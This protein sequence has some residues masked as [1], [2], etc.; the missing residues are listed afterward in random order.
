[1]IG[2]Y[3]ILNLSDGKM[4][5]GSG[6]HV[7]SRFG[8]HL[9]TLR[10]GT[11]HNRY[12]QE[13]WDKDGEGNFSFLLLE[14]CS[15]GQQREREQYWLD[16]V[17]DKYNISPSS[18]DGTFAEEHKRRIAQSKVGVPRSEETKRK[19]SEKLRGRRVTFSEE[20]RK[21]LSEARRRN[22]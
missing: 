12:L 14:E 7:P 5:I 11:N 1:M 13:A 16:N 19:L 22:I 18:K 4:Y 15:L 20:H 6:V 8:T 3:A 9:G 17:V 2:V 21:H 10:K